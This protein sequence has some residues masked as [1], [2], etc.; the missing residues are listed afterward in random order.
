MSKYKVI[1][2]IFPN[3]RLRKEIDWEGGGVCLEYIPFKDVEEIVKSLLILFHL[4]ILIC[5]FRI[6][7][8]KIGI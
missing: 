8:H 2:P 6:V 4:M 5:I 1:P 7:L 3:E